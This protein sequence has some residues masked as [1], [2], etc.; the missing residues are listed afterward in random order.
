MS[1]LRCLPGQGTPCLN[2]DV[3]LLPDLL[4]CQFSSS[5]RFV[6]LPGFWS[7]GWKAQIYPLKQLKLII[8]SPGFHLLDIGMLSVLNR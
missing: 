3:Y 2:T 6:A 1:P 5:Y 7:C 8:D 4:S